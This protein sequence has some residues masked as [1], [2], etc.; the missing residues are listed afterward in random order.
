MVSGLCFGWIDRLINRFDERFYRKRYTPRRPRSKWREI[1]VKR[2][3]QL[4]A[5]ARVQPRGLKQI[6]A[7]KAD[8]RWGTAYP[9]TSRITL[10]E[11]IAAVLAKSPAAGALF[12]TL[13]GAN[14]FAILYRLHD[15]RHPDKRAAAIGN[16]LA[17]LE[18]GETVHG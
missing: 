17:M 1:N 5:D 6:E 3:E 8:G 13:T 15:Q 10:P 16:W 9:P 18:R 14:R 7:A 2:A 4:V 12:A 11:N